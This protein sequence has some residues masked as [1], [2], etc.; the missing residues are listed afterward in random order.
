[1]QQTGALYF[2]ACKTWTPPSWGSRTLLKASPWGNGQI[3]AFPFPAHDFK[4]AVPLTAHPDPKERGTPP[5]PQAPGIG[6]SW[7]PASLSFLL[8]PGAVLHWGW[9]A[10]ITQLQQALRGLLNQ[11][12]SFWATFCSVT[13]SLTKPLAKTRCYCKKISAKLGLKGRSVPTCLGKP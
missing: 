13:L 8:H 5:L 7:Y 1:M 3:K 4:A 11:H 2:S 12:H 6:S 10:E 9:Y